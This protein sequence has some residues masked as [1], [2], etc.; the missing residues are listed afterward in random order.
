LHVAVRHCHLSVAREL[1][2]IVSNIKSRI[3]AVML[4][5]QQNWVRQFCHVNF[6]F[7]DKISKKYL[8]IFEN[9]FYLKKCKNYSSSFLYNENESHSS[10]KV[11]MVFYAKPSS[12]C[13]L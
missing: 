4:V 11:R 13:I 1:L 2:E 8:E 7:K 3:D 9:W 10:R 12:L 5:N 6:F